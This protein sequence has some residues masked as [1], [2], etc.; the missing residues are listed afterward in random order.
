MA[1]PAMLFQHPPPALKSV[2]SRTD[3]QLDTEAAA[4]AR[5]TFREASAQ[6]KKEEAKRIARAN[7]E[8]RERLSKVKDKTDSGD[9]TVNINADGI[10]LSGGEN[11][12]SK[13]VR[14]RLQGC[15]GFREQWAAAYDE[16]ILPLHSEHV[17]RL[18]T[19]GS[20]IDDDTEDDATGEA[21]AR[22]RE[23]SAARRLAEAEELKARN[24]E[25]FSQLSSVT[26]LTD[27]RIWDDGE[28]SAGAM[29]SVVAAES[30]ARKEEEARQ[31]AKENKEAGKRLSGVKARTDDGD[32]TQ[33]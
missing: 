5:T 15:K 21:R 17:Q 6:R 4:L 29:R 33:S 25:Y 20:A 31:L 1:P 8:N 23:E 28:G 10:V 30:R 18:P 26:T 9:N 19:I 24:Q 16:K 3:C 32:G 7:R 13:S 22:L 27:S 12:F 2:P 11:P 14:L